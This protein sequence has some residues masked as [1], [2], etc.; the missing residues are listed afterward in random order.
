VT[1]IIIKIFSQNRLIV[2]I[3]YLNRHMTYI[4]INKM[5]ERYET[6]LMNSS[7]NMTF[8][9]A[10]CRVTSFAKVK[11]YLLIIYLHPQ[12]I[13]ESMTYVK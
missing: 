3:I 2:E 12:H 1:K 8:N 11:L 7:D 9:C 4:D 5:C 10:T 13:S 6:H